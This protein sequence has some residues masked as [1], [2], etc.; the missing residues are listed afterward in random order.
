MCMY[1]FPFSFYKEFTCAHT[2][3]PNLPYPATPGLGHLLGINTH[4]VGGY[5]PGYPERVNRPGFKSLRTARVLEEG[6][7]ITVEP[8]RKGA[9]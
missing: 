6:M 4:D 7:V 9:G 1:Q 5:G 3:H 2:Q 8:V